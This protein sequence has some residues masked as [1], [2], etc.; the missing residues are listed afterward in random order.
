MGD[1]CDV[2]KRATCGC[3]VKCS[4]RRMRDVDEEDGVIGRSSKGFCV[5]S[6]GEED[7]ILWCGHC[8]LPAGT[9]PPAP[10]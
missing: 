7:C 8:L 6:I 10:T 3:E 2:T 1:D 9:L 4:A 5:D